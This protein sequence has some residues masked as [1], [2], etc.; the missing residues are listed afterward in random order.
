MRMPILHNL[1][2]Q[3][4]DFGSPQ[5]WVWPELVFGGSPPSPIVIGGPFPQAKPLPSP[6]P[7]RGSFCEAPGGGGPGC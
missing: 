3:R 6:R 4:I 5:M 2:M 1:I 7:P